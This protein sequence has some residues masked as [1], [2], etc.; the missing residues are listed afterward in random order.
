MDIVFVVIIL[1][2]FL[3][4]P[5]LLNYYAN[6]WFV[7]S[8]PDAPGRWELAI[9]GFALS[10]VILSVA[11]MLTLIVSLGADSLRDQ[12]AD[13]VRLGWRGYAEERPIALSGVLTAV[14]LVHMAL[15]TALGWLAIPGAYLK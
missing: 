9:A 14:A 12:V 3:V 1:S 7:G 15:M 10:F 2:A 8:R 4:V 13:F 6:R 11:A 5:A